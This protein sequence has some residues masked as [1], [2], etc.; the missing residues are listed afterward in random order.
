MAAL[1]LTWTSQIV[2]G[3]SVWSHS[4]GVTW[5]DGISLA[6]AQSEA[7]VLPA[8]HRASKKF[9]DGVS[10]LDTYHSELPSRA[11]IGF[12]LFPAAAEA[13]VEGAMRGVDSQEG[14]VDSSWPMG[15]ADIVEAAK[16]RVRTV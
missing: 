2:G 8:R 5:T 4:S 12:W 11:D 9:S 7:E 14:V 13:K 6:T 3:K 15:G 16:E 1:N 10:K